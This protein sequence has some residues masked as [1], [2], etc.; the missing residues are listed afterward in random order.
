MGNIAPRAGT[1]STS[2]TFWASVLTIKPPILPDVTTGPTQSMWLFW[3]RGQYRLLQWLL[4]LFS[5]LTLS[6]SEIEGTATA[7]IPALVL[8][9][10]LLSLLSAVMLVEQEGAIFPAVILF[11]ISKPC[12]YTTGSTYLALL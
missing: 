2:F 9:S 4:F 8:T 6:G 10:V 5:I 11:G 12:L 1:E 3:L 7:M